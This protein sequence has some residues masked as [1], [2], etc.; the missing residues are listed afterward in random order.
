MIEKISKERREC[1]EALI[2]YL[3]NYWRLKGVH[4]EKLDEMINFIV[5]KLKEKF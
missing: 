3:R 1:E 2:F 4:H 5:E